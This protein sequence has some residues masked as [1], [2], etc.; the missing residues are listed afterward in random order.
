MPKLAKGD[1]APDFTLLD[2]NKKEVSLNDYKGKKLL[3]YFYP[4]ANTPGCTKQSC[5][6]R[7]AIPDFKK[8]AIDAIGISPDA[9]DKQKIF[10]EK[11]NLGFP[12]LS[13]LEHEV[14]E[15]YSAYG[16]KNM[17][18]KKVMGIIR[19]SFLIDE[20]GNIIDAWYKVKPED[21]VPKALEANVLDS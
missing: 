2:Q 10:D 17:Y 12:L 13:D 18:G 9:P 20:K 4:K 21:T 6:V 8:L 14:A 15:T 3:I 1:K 5:A 16:E 11:F 19:S 7:D